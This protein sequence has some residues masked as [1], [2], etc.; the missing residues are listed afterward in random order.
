[1]IERKFIAQNMKEFRI[2]EYI[3]SVLKNVGHS[4][5]KIQRTPLGEK[6]VIFASRPG[7]IVGRKGQ[8]IKT[9]TKNLKLKFNLENP[10]IEISEIE[11]PR[12]DARI[13]GEKIVDSLEHFGTARF[14]GIAHIVM[15]DVMGNALEP[16]RPEMLKR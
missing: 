9:L 7:L 4:H 10:E 6:I 8:N 5:T 3:A 13:R 16:C 15:T 2:E 12:L 14:K 11:D 1:M